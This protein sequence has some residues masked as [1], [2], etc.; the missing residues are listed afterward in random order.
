MRQY[1]AYL[2]SGQDR[3]REWSTIYAAFHEFKGKTFTCPPSKQQR[4][5]YQTIGFK[6]AM[7]I[8]R[9]LPG[10]HFPAYQSRKAKHHVLCRIGESILGERADTPL[11]AYCGNG[12]MKIHR[13]RWERVAAG[14]LLLATIVLIAYFIVPKYWNFENHLVAKTGA[15]NGTATNESQEREGTPSSAS[16]GSGDG[17][18]MAQPEDP[19]ATASA[20]SKGSRTETTTTQSE[21]SGPDASTGSSGGT[22]MT[23]PQKQDATAPSASRGT[24]GTTT[25]SHKELNTAQPAA[26]VTPSGATTTSQKQAA[27]PTGASGEPSGSMTLPVIPEALRKAAEAACTTLP[28]RRPHLCG[29]KCTQDRRSASHPAG[30]FDQRRLRVCYSR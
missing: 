16:R 10:G 4:D 3:R 20:G 2:P 11:Y 5:T 28:S 18:A 22:A 7:A 12:L 23:Q 8:G 6:L 15:T 19:D 9:G 21:K 26:V 25:Q 29:C 13:F 17:A 30:A 1:D 24:G 14:V 27:T